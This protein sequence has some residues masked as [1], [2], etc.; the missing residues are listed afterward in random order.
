MTLD[1][2]SAR[3]NNVG[4]YYGTAMYSKV[5]FLPGYPYSHNIN[6]IELTIIKITSHPDLTIVTIYRSPQ[7]SI[8]QLCTALTEILQPHLQ[9]GVLRIFGTLMEWNRRQ[10]HDC[11]G[12]FCKLLHLLFGVRTQDFRNTNG[13][14]Q[15]T[16]T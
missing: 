5:P 7:I 8:H 6:G 11:S 9:F 16:V 13:M 14:E 15:K 2:H 10:S 4:P 12:L 3:V 1:V